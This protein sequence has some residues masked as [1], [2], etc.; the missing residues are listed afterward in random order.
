MMNFWP[1]GI[2]TDSE[3]V[4]EEA[5]CAITGVTPLTAVNKANMAIAIGLKKA[6]FL[7]LTTLPRVFNQTPYSVLYIG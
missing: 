2:V 1:E 6:T 3:P 5:V 7:T 4:V